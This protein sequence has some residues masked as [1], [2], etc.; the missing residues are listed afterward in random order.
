MAY[1][2]TALPSPTRTVGLNVPLLRSKSCRNTR[3]ADAPVVAG[4]AAAAGL[5]PGDLG[6]EQDGR[7]PRLRRTL[8]RTLRVDR[9]HE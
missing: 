2:A 3:V 6:V 8:D 1:D 7:A 4:H 9:Q 5:V